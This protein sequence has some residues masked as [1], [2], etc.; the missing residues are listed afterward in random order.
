MMKSVQ[1][2]VAFLMCSLVL[3][4]QTNCYYKV[5]EKRI[6]DNLNLDVFVRKMQTDSFKFSQDKH[7]IPAYVREQFDCLTRDTLLANPGEEWNS[8][9]VHHIVEGQPETTR[10]LV[11][12][13][14]SKEVMIIGYQKGGIV[15]FPKVLFMRFLDK[16]LV[17]VWLFCPDDISQFKTVKSIE[18]YVEENKSEENRLNSGYVSF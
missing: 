10:Q 18:K 15:V 17:D 4:A 7:T 2:I 14:E 3:R 1:I 11:F 8:T 9:D 5:D 12:Y 13:A 16:R 6:L